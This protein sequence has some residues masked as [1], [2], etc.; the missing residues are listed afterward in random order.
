MADKYWKE[1]AWIDKKVMQG[2]TKK[3]L[4]NTVGMFSNK[5]K[6][7][8]MAEKGLTEKEYRKRYNFLH[9]VFNIL[10]NQL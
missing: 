3:E 7:K 5:S 6:K 2:V 9:N 4:H 10:D 1:R 8:V